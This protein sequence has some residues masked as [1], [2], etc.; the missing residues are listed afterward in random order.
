MNRREC[1]VRVSNFAEKQIRRLP[2]YI[3]EA[4]SVWRACVEQSGIHEVRKIP[5]YHDEPLHGAREG[6]RSARLNRAY[7]VIYTESDYGEVT[8]IGVLE[9][10]KH[11]Y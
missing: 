8:V 3:I 10:N 5:G 4:L 6:Q 11:E 2:K 1:I 9:V 7:R